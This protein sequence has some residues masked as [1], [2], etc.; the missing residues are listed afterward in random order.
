MP[1]LETLLT[2]DQRD[3]MYSHL[4]TTSVVIIILCLLMVLWAGVRR[5]TR[6]SLTLLPTSDSEDM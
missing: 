4:M 6:D 3:V 5:D 1:G 2:Q